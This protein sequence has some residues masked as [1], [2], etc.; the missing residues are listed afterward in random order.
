MQTSTVNPE[1]GEVLNPESI[2]DLILNRIA[3]HICLIQAYQVFVDPP[4]QN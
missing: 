2:S 3:S 4:M 1:P